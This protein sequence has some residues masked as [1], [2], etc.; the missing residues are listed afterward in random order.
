MSKLTAKDYKKYG[1]VKSGGKAKYPIKNARSARSALKL[2][3][4]AKPPLNSSQKANVRRE[5][6]SFGVKP[7][8]GSAAD[9]K[10]KEKK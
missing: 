9:P 2:I 6:A 5:A 3:N 1:T 4:N 10:K 8:P 7:K